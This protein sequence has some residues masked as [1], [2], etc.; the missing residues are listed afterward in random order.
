MSKF[1][2]DQTQNSK[3]LKQARKRDVGKKAWI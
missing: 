1:M 2:E 3:D